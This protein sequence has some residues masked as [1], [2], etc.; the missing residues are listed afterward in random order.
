MAENKPAAKRYL[1]DFERP[2]DELYQKI[3]ELRQLTE[4]SQIDLSEEISTM[5]NRAK[6]LSEKIYKNMK[7]YQVVQMARHPQRPT[8]LDI[9]ALI[10]DDFIELHGDRLFGDD[11][12]LI[13]GPGYLDGRIPV[14]FIGHQKGK[15]TKDNIYRN[16]GMANPE[17]YRKALRLMKMAENFRMPI[18]T[19]VD[20][21]G[22]Y[23]GLGAEER[24]QSEA[25]AR[26]LMEMSTLKV[27]VITVIVGEGGSGGA[28]GIAVA[29]RVYMLEFSI[30][31]VISPEGCA[32]ILF[33]DAALAQQASQALQLTAKDLLKNKIVE[34]IIAEPLGGAHCNLEQ[35]AADI[36]QTLLSGLDDFR[37]MNPQQLINQRLTK[38]RDFGAY[39][40][41]AAKSPHKTTA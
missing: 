30:Y 6:E 37:S 13:G 28:L 19:F 22:A 17:G 12:A 3:N 40:D 21:P 4:S 31:S 15:D 16:F 32:S 1:M 39:I 33:R 5:E 35:C 24:G 11:P 38:F 41:T 9:V 20:T 25:I 10:A 14:M 27:P 36:K 23:P 8:M 7:P 18:I 26:N 2:L 34:G 29:N